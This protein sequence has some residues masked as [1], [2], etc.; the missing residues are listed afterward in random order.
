MSFGKSLSMLAASTATSVLAVGCS[1]SAPAPANDTTTSSAALASLDAPNGGLDL[2]SKEAPAFGDPEVE[3]LPVM[4]D[5]ATSTA[6]SPVPKSA[7]VT[8][9]AAPSYD[10][11]LVWGHLPPSH[12]SSGT[13]VPAQVAQWTGSIGVS[14][15]T[16][17][18]LRTIGFAN[19]DAAATASAQSL[20]F[21]SQTDGYVDGVL[22]RVAVPSGAAATLHFG[23]SL[24]TNDIDLTRLDGSPG[25]VA[26]ASDGVSGLGWIGFEETT[27]AS[28]FVLGRWVKDA[29]ALGRAFGVVSDARGALVGYVRGPWGFSPGRSNEVWFQKLIDGSGNPG[30]LA[31]GAYGNG[32]AAGPWAAPAESDVSGVGRIEGLYSDADDTGDGRGVWIGRWASACPD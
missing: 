14:A 23:T 16:V 31:Y 32:A 12:D 18:L 9:P 22:L 6:P 28:G 1:S 17:T 15:G 27:C 29:P 10:V 7:D 3:A 30:G 2:A 24:L 11:M 13:D 21:D 4:V 5:A 20:T 19:G 8:E 25:G 26:N